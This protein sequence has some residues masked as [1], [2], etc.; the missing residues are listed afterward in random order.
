MCI[1]KSVWNQSNVQAFKDSFHSDEAR[2]R[3]E[4]AI[5]MIDVDIN[6]ALQIFNSSIKEMAECMKK[7]Y[8]RK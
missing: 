5:N 7:T 1:D 6:N 3:L 4:H 8:C 2:T